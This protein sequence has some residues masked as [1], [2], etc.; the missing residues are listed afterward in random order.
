[1]ID[2]TYDNLTL[3]SSGSVFKRRPNLGETYINKF[4]ITI[5]MLNG[6]PPALALRC[7]SRDMA[8]HVLQSRISGSNYIITVLWEPVIPTGD[9]GTLYWYA[10]YPASKTS[11]GRGALVIRNPRTGLVT[12]DSDLKYLRVRDLI[13]GTANQTLSYPADRRYAVIPMRIQYEC[14]TNNT[15]LEHVGAWRWYADWDIMGSIWNGNNLILK[16]VW[17]H[18]VDEGIPGAVGGI[19]RQTGYSF[20]VVDVTGY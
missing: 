18:Q 11:A 5:P 10:F 6:R 16:T 19:W 20:L 1:M 12:F 14:V 17:F 7:E 15:Y 2:D 4:D 3:H 9:N 13:Q 8:M